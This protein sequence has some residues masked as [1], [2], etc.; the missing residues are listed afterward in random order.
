MIRRAAAAALLLALAM[1]LAAC[2]EE[3]ADR[4]TGSPTD[5]LVPPDPPEVEADQLAALPAGKL[6]PLRDGERRMTLTMPTEY[7][8][9]APTGTGTD[10][11]RC[12]LLDP[13]LDKDVWLTGGHVAPGNPRVVH[14]VILFR[15]APE[16]VAEAEDLDARTSEEGW[17][18]FGGSGLRADFANLDDAFWLAA[19]APGGDET[20]TRDG[21]G[22]RLEAGS[23]IIMQVH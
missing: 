5:I 22:V 2:V 8:P 15:V 18:C 14:H 21:Y 6:L 16:Q 19:W 12:F 9:S 1:S 10:D 3:G 7:T 11:Y 23:R 4:R 17:T 13:G 20:R